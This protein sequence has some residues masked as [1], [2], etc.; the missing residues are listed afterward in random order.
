MVDKW[1]VDKWTVGLNKEGLYNGVKPPEERGSENVEE[2]YW[3]RI[4]VALGRTP[5]DTIISSKNLLL[6][7]GI[8]TWLCVLFSSDKLLA[9]VNCCKTFYQPNSLT[10][11]LTNL[12]VLGLLGP[13][14][15][16]SGFGLRFVSLQLVPSVGRISASEVYNSYGR[17]RTTTD[18]STSRR[19]SERQSTRQAP[20]PWTGKSRR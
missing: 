12:F 6:G 19:V 8:N 7:L 11:S 13:S 4:T 15:F 20:Q 1:T 14:P 5:L 2:E 18:Q 10:H 3:G 16:L 17:F 9:S